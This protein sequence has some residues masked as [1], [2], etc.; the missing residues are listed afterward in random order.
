[1]NFKRVIL[2]PDDVCRYGLMERDIIIN[3]VN[4]LSHL[5]KCT[6]VPKLDEPTVFE[7]NMMRLRV[8]ETK[9]VPAYL[10]RYLITE[11]SRERIRGMAKRAVAQ[12]RACPQL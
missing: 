7:S 3:R 4:S 1:M 2:S 9:L 5:G 10:L 12:A 11:E 6:L 8:D